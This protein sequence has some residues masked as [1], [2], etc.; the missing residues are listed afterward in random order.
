MTARQP[1][2]QVVVP[3]VADADLFARFAYL[4][5]LALSQKSAELRRRAEQDLAHIKAITGG[6]HA[7]TV[8]R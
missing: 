8:Q 4:Q 2:D 3:L 5:A 6:A 1:L 7:P